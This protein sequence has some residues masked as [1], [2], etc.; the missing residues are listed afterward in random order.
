MS[1]NTKI[2]HQPGNDI[3]VLGE[4]DVIVVGG[5]PAFEILRGLPLPK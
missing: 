2:Y 4:W 5:E 1:Q 3:P